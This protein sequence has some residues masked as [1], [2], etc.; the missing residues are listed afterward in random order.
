M[1]ASWFQR[2][3]GLSLDPVVCYDRLGFARVNPDGLLGRVAH[4]VCLVSYGGDL[5]SSARWSIVAPG[6]LSSLRALHCIACTTYGSR[7]TALAKAKAMVGT[8]SDQRC[9]LDVE[10]EKGDERLY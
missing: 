7:R 4:L 1:R 10:G 5:F 3:H 8:D 9:A 2:M 6:G